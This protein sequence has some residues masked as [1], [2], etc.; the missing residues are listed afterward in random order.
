[1]GRRE[2]SV[3]DMRGG[4]GRSLF[5]GSVGRREEARLLWNCLTEGLWQRRLALKKSHP[6]L[7]IALSIC[8]DTHVVGRFLPRSHG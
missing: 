4:A 7:Q 5:F 3:P 8:L 2:T 1:M 6:P